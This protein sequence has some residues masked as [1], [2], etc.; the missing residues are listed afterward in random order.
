MGKIC[1]LRYYDLSGNVINVETNKCEHGWESF[2]RVEIPKG[3]TLK[4]GILYLCDWIL[5]CDVRL[6]F[7]VEGNVKSYYF[8]VS[9]QGQC[10][11]E[12]VIQTP[13]KSGWVLVYAY[14]KDTF[15]NWVEQDSMFFWV[16]ILTPSVKPNVT[17]VVP[18]KTEYYTDEDVTG[19]AYVKNDGNIGGNVRIKV[20][21]DGVTKY[22]S[23]PKFI[24][25]G[26]LV[27]FSFNLGKLSAGERE[28]CADAE[29]V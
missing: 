25:A 12:T 15:G 1:G 23:N 22:T 7:H 20:T 2:G 4:V 26:Q 24:G 3:A 13:T 16:E 6:D 19:S 5:G 8:R 29:V 17:K 9:S 10:W 18:S 11:L 14:Q 21:V 28:I 27:V